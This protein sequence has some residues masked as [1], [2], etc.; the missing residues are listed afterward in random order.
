MHTQLK[1]LHIEDYRNQNAI[2]TKGR[3]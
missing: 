3:E 2:S 1:T